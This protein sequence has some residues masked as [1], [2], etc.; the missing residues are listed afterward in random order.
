MLPFLFNRITSYSTNRTSE[1]PRNVKRCGLITKCRGY[2]IANK[3]DEDFT[4][5][6]ADIAMALSAI[7]TRYPDLPVN[8]KN[9]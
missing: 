9:Q 6:S 3:S 5:I 2:T 1:K 4:L 7:H 8:G